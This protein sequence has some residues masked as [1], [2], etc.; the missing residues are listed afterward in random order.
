[1][2]DFGKANEN[3]RKAITTTEGPVLIIAGPGT[4]KTYT[5][6]QRA[7]YLIEE[8]QV[9]AEN[10]FIATFTNK[11]AREL[12]TRLTNK[13]AN[14][15][16][17][18]NLNEMYIGT[19]H[20]LCQRI[21]T[22]Y[23][24]YTR[25]SKNFLPL[26]DFA[27]PYKVFLNIDRF[28]S[29]PRAKEVLETAARRRSLRAD[30]EKWHTA[31]KLCSYV[32]FLSEELIAPEKLI[33][34]QNPHLQT[35]GRLFKEYLAFIKE[36]DL[37]DYSSIM[38]ET[39]RLLKDNPQILAKLRN[40]ITHIMVDEYQDTNYIQEKLVFLLAGESKN[41]CVVGDDDQGLYR[42][43]GATIRNILEFPQKFANG[44]CQI[45][46]LEINYRSNRGIVDFCNKWMT[47]TKDFR[48]EK[49]RYPK[50]IRAQN[51]RTLN[52][53]SV[54][55][56]ASD[57]GG[58]DWHKRVLQF[59]K[60]LKTSGKITDYNQVAF[61]FWSIKNQEV[62]ELANYLDTNGVPVYSPRAASFFLRQE[63]C[64]ALGCLAL[65]FPRYSKWTKANQDTEECAKYYQT[66]IASVFAYFKKPESA[67]LGRFLKQYG[68]Q[69]DNLTQ[70]AD[71]AY[72]GLL[73]RLFEFQPFA[74]YLDTD[75]TKGVRDIRPARNLAILS[76]LIGQYEHLH[77][78][79]RLNEPGPDGTPT[80]DRDT[81]RLF[82]QYLTFLRVAG[83]N[84]YEDDSEY[85]PS[86]CV[87]FNTI[88]QSKGME[89]PIVIVG[90]LDRYPSDQKANLKEI[91]LPKYGQ[92]KAF[93]P[94]EKTKFYDFW[95]LFY[96]A[97]S[98]AQNL[99]I[100]T[101]Q[102]N[103]HAYHQE[104]NPCFYGVYWDLLPASDP[105]FHLEEIQFHPV[106]DIQL[107]N[108][109]SFTSHIAMYDTCPLQYKFYKELG[110]APVLAHATSFGTLVHQTIE[111]VHRA[112]LKGEE[113]TL[114]ENT[115]S[116]WFW[117][118]YIS[119][120]QTERANFPEHQ[121]EQALQQVLHYVARNNGDWSHIQQAEFD[122]SLVKLKF[123]IAG[124]IDL[125]RGD[126][127]TVEIVD[128]KSGRKPKMDSASNWWLE[129]YRTQL[130]IYA[131]LV[132]ERT[133]QKVSQMHLYYTGENQEDPYITF[134]YDK[135]A[136]DET[137]DAFD[138]T[139]A[140]IM[141]KSF[142]RRTSDKKRCQSCDFRFYCGTKE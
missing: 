100:L 81:S 76:K 4:G 133:G 101:C 14:R 49:F 38:V 140:K 117:A 3:Q 53:P 10:I 25:L 63:I 51:I 79:D 125:V 58:E 71:Y 15:G 60:S 82:N 12:I 21:L 64:L 109:Y 24:A 19:F 97:F 61:L 83:I 37:L 99:L 5:L 88:H 7:V 39:Y 141:D 91:I 66:C 59:V 69:H 122:V 23:L 115:I 129:R 112:V 136:V 85:A 22:E 124:K 57:K 135:R 128:F 108:T 1:M 84:E 42:F 65:L 96:T 132:E 126:N 68:Q 43:R 13:L 9:K 86:G 116:N 55:R 102:E 123:I 119:L 33:Q 30:E 111:D 139:V 18:I 120:A 72:S 17:P 54:V 103:K 90:S 20:S 8:R 114:T 105:K 87:S 130:Q 29:I 74:G 113:H 110:F 106:K 46:P 44:E 89:F 28:I 16:I 40:K 118:N 50:K 121:L 77:H 98:R 142:A 70:P 127:D 80:L 92:R 131:R 36:N 31:V 35:L 138:N 56:L 41:I 78:I 137:M 26:D 134:P 27:Q 32:N 107:K 95:R 104:P 34:D 11:A 2:F 94:Y 45:I 48:W 52:T 47:A 62:A 67:E 6:V 75:V 93:E 73:Y